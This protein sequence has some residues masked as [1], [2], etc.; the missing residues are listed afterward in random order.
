MV[1]FIMNEERKRILKMV[2]EGSLTAEEALILLER[3]EK[4]NKN[5]KQTTVSTHVHMDREQKEEA[6]TKHTTSTTSKLMDFLDN[7]L[8]KIKDLDLDLNFGPAVEIS[9]I[10][11]HSD[12]VLNHIEVDVANGSVKILPWDEKEIRVECEA[13]IY[14]A[15]T[16]EAA[17]KAFLQDVVFSVEAG[18]LRFSVQKKQMKV[19]AVIYIPRE[20]YDFV[21]IRM[22]NG[23][24]AGERLH[25]KDLKAKTANGKIT[26]TQVVTDDLEVETANG[27]IHVIGDAKE[28]EAETINGKIDV[29][30][31]FEKTDLRSF[32]GSIVLELQ[33]ENCQT[34]HIKT[35]TGNIDIYL[36]KETSVRGELKSNFGKLTCR[37]QE[38]EIIKEKHDAVQKILHFKANKEKGLPFHL[39][40]ET[41]AG[42]VIIK[43]CR[44]E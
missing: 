6:Q 34:A 32:N 27:H 12:V 19:N 29:I 44:G 38:M 21:T 22:F 40:A 16:Q 18:K 33:N 30:G 36:P 17:R 3:L 15:E 25:A 7:V 13:K 20:E 1:V 26:M 41:K 11:Q 35:T 24:I 2:E 43:P 8:K 31:R 10:F 39:F 5:E 28:M 37:L 42:S 14:K 9:H 23:S 4:E